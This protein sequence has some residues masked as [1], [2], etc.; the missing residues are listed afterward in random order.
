[1]DVITIREFAFFVLKC[2]NSG[3]SCER[4]KAGRTDKPAEMPSPVR[5]KQWWAEGILCA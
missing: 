2:T 4:I 3:V 1:M 5:S